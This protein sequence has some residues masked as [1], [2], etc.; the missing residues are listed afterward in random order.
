MAFHQISSSALAKIQGHV[1]QM[2]QKAAVFRAKAE[3]HAHT[4]K[5]VGEMVGGAVAINYV[6]GVYEAKNGAGSFKVPGT[7][8]DGE[9][10]VAG[11]L[12]G[13]SL[14]E[15][16]GQYNDDLLNVGAGALSHYAG[17][18]ARNWGKNGKFS[19]DIFVAGSGPD[20]LNSAL[21]ESL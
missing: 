16:G 8:L 1:G 4:A 3:K 19:K 11:V 12:I 18:A 2:T 7:E 5:K 10:A 6:R 15:Q 9:L 21:S 13:L 14:F 20:L 17:Q